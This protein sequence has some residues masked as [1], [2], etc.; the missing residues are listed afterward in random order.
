VTDLASVASEPHLLHRQVHPSWVQ[1]GRVTSQA[2]CPTPKDFGL[3]SVYDGSRIWPQTSFEHYTT[4]Q[5]LAAIGTV[6]ALATEVAEVGLSWRP[7]PE[8]FPEHAVIDFTGL[9]GAGKVKA[10]AQALAERARR[11]GWTYQPAD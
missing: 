8:P 11:R 4:V 2:F 7:D 9:A 6:S 5:R 3:L 10:T 1:E